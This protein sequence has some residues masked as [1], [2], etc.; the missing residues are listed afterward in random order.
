[1]RLTNYARRHGENG[2]LPVKVNVCLDEFCNIG[3]IP[4]FKKLISTVHSCSINCQVIVQEKHESK[5]EAA[6][7]MPVERDG[8]GEPAEFDDDTSLL[9]DEIS[10]EEILG[11]TGLKDEEGKQ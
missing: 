8:P 9:P 2:R 1:M 4:D 5:R 3:K 7:G 10:P 6:H 11:T